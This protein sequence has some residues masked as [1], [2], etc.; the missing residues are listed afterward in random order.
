M[1]R[2]TVAS[3]ASSVADLSSKLDN[4]ADLVAASIVGPTPSDKPNVTRTTS[5]AKADKA[6]AAKA[7]KEADAKRDADT[8]AKR[9]AEALRADKVKQLRKL[10]REL[11]EPESQLAGGTDAPAPPTTDTHN[12]GL[13]VRDGKLHIV[14]AL[15][16]DIVPTSQGSNVYGLLST[17]GGGMKDRLVFGEN[18]TDSVAKGVDLPNGMALQLRLSKRIS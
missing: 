8:K 13:T 14:I 5:S 16:G 6:A 15:D 2:Q 12:L 7:R 10:Q 3:V 11:G 18:A 4:L 9:E 17:T 1:A